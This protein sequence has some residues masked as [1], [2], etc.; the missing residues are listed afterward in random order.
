LH[1][2]LRRFGALLLGGVLFLGLHRAVALATADRHITLMSDLDRAIPLM[3][4]TAWFYVPLYALGILVAGFLGRERREFDRAA[5]AAAIGLLFCSVGY[6]LVPSAYPRAEAFVGASTVGSGAAWMRFVH[7]IDPPNNT[8][9]SAHV[10]VAVIC[11]DIGW[12]SG[13]RWRWVPALSAIGVALSVLTTKQHYIVDSI[14]G[15]AIG[16]GSL[17]LGTRWLVWRDAVG[18]AE[19]AE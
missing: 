15:A 9:P 17:W 18:D 5:M 1:W 4:W 2:Y 10:M 7:A 8:F 13:S 14:A 3:Q 12:R 16:A 11:A 6:F 19:T